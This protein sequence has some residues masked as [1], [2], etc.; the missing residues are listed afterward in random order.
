M[1][2]SRPLKRI[3]LY[4]LFLWG[5]VVFCFFFCVFLYDGLLVE[6]WRGCFDYS[7]RAG[8]LMHIGFTLSHMIGTVDLVRH[9]CSRINR[10]EVLEIMDIPFL[11]SG[12]I[13]FI[14]FCLLLKNLRFILLGA[15][16]VCSCMIM[17]DFIYKVVKYIF[18]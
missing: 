5:L 1:E 3:I 17:F 12:L 13:D 18:R 6:H 15:I 7:L 11:I 4:N 16:I 14:I 9:V 2:K 10:K 8:Y